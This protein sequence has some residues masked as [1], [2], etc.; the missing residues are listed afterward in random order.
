MTLLEEARALKEEDYTPESWEELASTL[1][2]LSHITSDNITTI[3]DKLISTYLEMLQEAVNGLQ[4]EAAFE[5]EDGTYLVPFKVWR[6]REKST[7]LLL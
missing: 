5:L 2:D 7:Q 4:R 3:S 1:A 6:E